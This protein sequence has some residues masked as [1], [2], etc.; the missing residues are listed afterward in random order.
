MRA[1]SFSVSREIPRRGVDVMV[2]RRFLGNTVL[3][4]MVRLPCGSMAWQTD[5]EL[6]PLV[7]QLCLDCADFAVFALRQRSDGLVEPIVRKLSSK[8]VTP[9]SKSGQ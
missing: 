9:N 2:V 4:S 7:V 5:G 1:R 3:L 6:S 8:P